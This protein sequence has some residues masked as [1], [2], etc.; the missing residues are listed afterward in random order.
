M[1][2]IVPTPDEMRMICQ[3]LSGAGLLGLSGAHLL[4][5]LEI[6][7]N[8]ALPAVLNGQPLPALGQNQRS[9]HLAIAELMT[10]SNPCETE[11]AIRDFHDLRAPL[12]AAWGT[13]HND[14]Q[15]MRK[16]VDQ[17]IAHGSLKEWPGALD[18]LYYMIL[19][20]HSRNDNRKRPFIPDYP[21]HDPRLPHP[22]P[23][24]GVEWLVNFLA[25]GLIPN[26]DDSWGGFP[27]AF[28]MDSLRHAAEIRARL[29]NPMLD[30]RW[31]SSA[32]IALHATLDGLHFSADMT[33]MSPGAKRTLRLRSGT[34]ILRGSSEDQFPI[35]AG[36][37][38]IIR[39]LDGG[40][41]QIQVAECRPNAM[42][43]PICLLKAGEKAT[44]E[45]T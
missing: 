40:K 7:A 45:F 13:P 26:L 35:P 17:V 11:A 19:G 29:L 37:R 10:R 34:A 14:L 33:S 25:G 21:P 39:A 36:Q 9:L 23:T 8:G 30:M 38:L 5:H 31:G 27:G 41:A 6:L 20:D 16:T 44:I 1:P 18:A 28:A 24:G 3:A 15:K 42:A 12:L 43:G 4:S 2:N 32:K 22:I